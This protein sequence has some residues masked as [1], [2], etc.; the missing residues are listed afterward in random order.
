[1][2][3]NWRKYLVFISFGIIAAF[4]VWIMNYKIYG[5]WFPVR[6]VLAVLFLVGG[7]F[8]LLHMGF[9]GLMIGR[10]VWKRVWGLSL[11]ILLIVTLYDLTYSVVYDFYPAMGI[12]LFR[13]DLPFHAERFKS[14]IFSNFSLI[15]ISALLATMIRLY[16]MIHQKTKALEIQLTEMKMQFSTAQIYPHFVESVTGSAIGR[17]LLNSAFGD[18]QSVVRLAQVMRY[19]L[20]AQGDPDARIPLAEEWGQ[21]NSLVKVVQ[22]KYGKSKVQVTRNGSF[23][24]EMKTVPVSLLTLFENAIKYA[25]LKGDGRIILEMSTDHTG[26]TFTCTNRIDPPKQVSIRG[27]GFG[28][29]NLQKRID[30]SG[31]PIHLETR[32][33]GGWYYA[34][35]VHGYAHESNRMEKSE[36]ELNR[37]EAL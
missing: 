11:I 7:Y 25:D 20:T 16:L 24:P 13:D 4:V 9:N 32:N 2:N 31:L 18:R 6:M 10:T 30:Q 22:W 35:L 26:Y 17:S 3:V 34:I 8:A 37:K 15:F 29:S 5:I 28:L 12:Q 27:S 19:V 36:T 14:R 33:E 21:L 1:M 23:P